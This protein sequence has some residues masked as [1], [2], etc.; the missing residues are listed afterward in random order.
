MTE[1]IRVK[2]PFSATK[3]IAFS[4]GSEFSRLAV[5]LVFHALLCLCKL[6]FNLNSFCFAGGGGGAAEEGRRR[7]RETAFH[8]GTWDHI[9]FK[10]R[11]A[12]CLF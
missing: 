10:A 7:N 6:F 4:F 11:V 12:S 1:I 5:S 2:W 8:S 3:G 9:Q